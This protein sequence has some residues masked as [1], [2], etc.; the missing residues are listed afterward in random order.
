MVFIDLILPGM[1]GIEVLRR[2]KNIY[3][4]VSVIIMSGFSSIGISFSSKEKLNSSDTPLDNSAGFLLKPF[5]TEEL[6]SLIENVLIN[7]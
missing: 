3:P 4:S 5:T 6:K 2:I 7:N 1:N